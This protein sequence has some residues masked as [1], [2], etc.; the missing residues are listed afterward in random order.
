MY[1]TSSFASSLIASIIGYMTENRCNKF[2][3]SFLAVEH[4]M[5]GTSEI[6]RQFVKNGHWDYFFIKNGKLCL[7]MKYNGYLGLSDCDYE[8]T[9]GIVTFDTKSEVFGNRHIMNIM[10]S[11]L[12]NLVRVAY[13]TIGN[14]HFTG[15]GVETFD[16][17]EIDELEAEYEAR[18][19]E[20]A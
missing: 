17:S 4:E 18:R 6:A 11:D 19:N 3:M 9:D 1:S 12:V 15:L 10:T 14:I 5:P 8:I 13:D 20:V 7:H 2:P 16:C